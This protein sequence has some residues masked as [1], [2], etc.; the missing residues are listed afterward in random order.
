VGVVTEPGVDPLAG[1][2]AIE[3]IKRLKARYCRAVDD[4]DREA[5]A[6]L[7]TEHCRMRVDFHPR[8]IVGREAWVAFVLGGIASGTTVHQAYLPD[9]E[10]DG[11]DRARGTWSLEDRV[12]IPGPPPMRFHGWARYDETYVR[13]ADGAWRIDSLA[14]TYHRRDPL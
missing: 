12:D 8:E 9:I 2:V 6:A 7:F 5:F 4:Q 10:M 14:L 11:P 13:E 3:D 1:L